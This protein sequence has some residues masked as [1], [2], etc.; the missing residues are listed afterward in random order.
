MARQEQIDTQEAPR[1]AGGTPQPTA[2]AAAD[3]ISAPYA[4]TLRDFPSGLFT[5]DEVTIPAGRW[6][7]P[8]DLELL[9]RSL[10]VDRDGKPEEIRYEDA[11]TGQV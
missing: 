2:A 6:Q 10:D 11:R 5:T 3:P 7:N 9:R 8:G 1:S 4:P